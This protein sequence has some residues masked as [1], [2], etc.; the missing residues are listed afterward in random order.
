MQATILVV[1]DEKVNQELVSRLLESSGHRVVTADSGREALET[2]RQDVPDL[3]VL[4]MIM[5]EMDGLQVLSTLKNDPELRRIPV[6]VVSALD[7]VEEIANCITLGASD[8]LVKP[9]NRTI[10]EA[11]V[12]ASLAQ[13]GLK[14]HVLGEA[15][16]RTRKLES[17]IQVERKVL[18][19]A[20]HDLRS[21]LTAILG[22]ADLLL[23]GTPPLKGEQKEFAEEILKAAS[24]MHR[25]VDTFLDMSSLGVEKVKPQLEQL[26]A[27]DLVE[28]EVRDAAS[29]SSSRGVQIRHVKETG[30][31]PIHA[32]RSLFTQA[33]RFLL[34]RSLESVAKGTEIQISTES[35]ENQ[36][37][38]TI[39]WTDAESEGTGTVGVERDLGLALTLA[40][41]ILV[42]QR[43]RLHSEFLDG[44][45]RIQM[46]LPAAD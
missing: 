32:D 20:R 36:S 11:R 29:L 28:C 6:I 18:S 30:S 1:D 37:R 21:P 45:I 31:C 43:G 39:A 3:V 15:E 16:D 38:I 19:I 2:I 27:H 10:L 26:D 22:Y 40:N 44:G 41:G 4:D 33:F 46:E 8:Y 23:S 13:S 14:D 34:R 35:R 42:A 25:I 5:P 17:T 24:N 9:F 12:N 7:D